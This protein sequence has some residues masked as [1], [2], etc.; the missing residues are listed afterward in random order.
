LHVPH[1]R[2]TAQIYTNSIEA[3]KHLEDYNKVKERHIEIFN[4]FHNTLD[5]G[6]QLL[7]EVK[8]WLEENKKMC[9]A[10]CKTAITAKRV[11]IV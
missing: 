7:S 8:I 11:Y 6:Y 3:I 2:F 5:N 1:S 4:E 9:K 10:K